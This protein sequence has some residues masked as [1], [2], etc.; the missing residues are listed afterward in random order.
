MEGG[1]R[2]GTDQDRTTT[3]TTELRIA[4]HFTIP[5]PPDTSRD[6]AVQEAQQLRDS[7]GGSIHFLYPWRRMR[8]W[9]P[10]SLCGLGMKESLRALDGEVD[11]HIYLE[12]SRTELALG[13]G[14]IKGLYDAREVK[15]AGLQQ[16]LD[17]LAVLI[18]DRVNERFGKGLRRGGPPRRGE[19]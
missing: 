11:L 4:Y 6:A 9:L 10:S 15:V 1:E 8:P 7:F 18:M 17:D 13:D 19:G 5:Q 12:N 3:G 14:R 2:P 16:S